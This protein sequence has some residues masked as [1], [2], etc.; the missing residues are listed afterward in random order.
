MT[1]VPLHIPGTRGRS[2]ERPASA[3]MARS[4][5]RS[6]QRT[7]HVRWT[8]ETTFSLFFYD[9]P[10]FFFLNTVIKEKSHMISIHLIYL[11][12]LHVSPS[13]PIYCHSEWNFNEDTVMGI[14]GISINIQTMQIWRS[15]R[16]QKWMGWMGFTNENS[17][18]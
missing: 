15:F 5:E 12:Y 17:E 14:S 6:T 3:E 2:L 9:F 13:V 16:A 11:I 4:R 1:E 10:C 8:K 18:G 7:T